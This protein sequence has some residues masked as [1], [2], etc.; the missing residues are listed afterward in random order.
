VPERGAQFNDF[1]TV[2]RKPDTDLRVGSSGRPMD[3]L[4][5]LAQGHAGAMCTAKLIVVV[6][7]AGLAGLA[8]VLEATYF[9]IACC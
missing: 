6:G 8:G 5:G 4:T 3:P 9:P 2:L 1:I 7:C